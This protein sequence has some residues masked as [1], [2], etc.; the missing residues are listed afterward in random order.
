MKGLI[1][2]DL[3]VLRKQ[4]KIFALLIVFFAIVP[5]YGEN[6]S[7]FQGIIV[8]L[9][10]MLPVTALSYDERA[11]WEKYA[12]T[13]PLNRRTLVLGKYL[14]GVFFILVAIAICVLAMLLIGVIKKQP[15]SADYVLTELVFLA[16]G[17]IFLSL[18]LP[19]MFKFG[20]EKGRLAL[21]GFAV[22]IML[23]P[24]LAENLEW[25]GD[26][27]PA[28]LNMGFLVVVSLGI[29]LL[30]VLSFCLSVRIYKKREMA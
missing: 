20:T 5:L 27:A 7:I 15:L 19:M 26:G 25:G 13:M 2:K 12:L 8:V 16:V 6:A 10:A 29:L 17:L 1:L 3:F 18:I 21:M 22:I 14:L 11:H 9:A 28:F 24:M 4:W 30:P 23:A